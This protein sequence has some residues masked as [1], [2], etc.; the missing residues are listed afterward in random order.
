[1]KFERQKKHNKM[2]LYSEFKDQI[3]NAV[4]WNKLKLVSCK[5]LFFGMVDHKEAKQCQIPSI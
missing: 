4:F 3:I 2:Y 5:G 1:M